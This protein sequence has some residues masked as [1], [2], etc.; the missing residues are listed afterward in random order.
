MGPG[1]H[2][3]PSVELVTGYFSLARQLEAADARNAALSAEAQARLKPE[4][5]AAVLAIAGGSAAFAGVGSPLTHAIG[6]GMNG[7]VTEAD[8]DRIESFY[9]ERGA[10]VNIDLCPLADLSLAELLA[11][12]G[13]RCVEFNNVLV[14]RTAPLEFADARVRRAAPEDAALWSRTLAEGF[15]E[16]EPTPAELEIGL[17]LFHM[18]GSSAWF[19]R[20]DGVAAAGGALTLGADGVATLCADATLKAHRGCGLQQALIQARLADAASR[21]AVLATA[22]TMPV[23]VS[24]RNYERCGFRVAYTKMNMQRDLS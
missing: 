5:G 12:R 21:G 24:Q 9:F 7:P 8:L 23:T 3:R 16:H 1:S 19:A 14:R 6:V 20:V 18:H 11:R 13:Y 15:F 17:Y 4:A 10:Q 2:E 22:A